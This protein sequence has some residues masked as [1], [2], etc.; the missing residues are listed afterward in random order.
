MIV[1][2]RGNVGRESTW[3]GAGILSPLLPWDYADSVNRLSEYSRGLFQAWCA[4]LQSLSGI[5]PEF[6]NTGMLVL[7]PF[8]HPRAEAWCLDH[9]WRFARRNSGD[10]L[11]GGATEDALW[12]P[13][14][15]QVRNPRLVKTLR[16]AAKAMGVD[17]RENVQVT[18]FE[19]QDGHIRRVLTKRE[20][21]SVNTCIIAAGAWSGDFPGLE[22][23]SQRIYPVRGQIL[24][25]KQTLGCL[26]SVIYCNGHYMVPRADGH[27]LVGSTL[28]YVGFDKSTTETARREIQ[29]FAV[30]LLPLLAD[31]ELI[32]HWSGLRP[33][34]P[35]N[36]PVIG[37]H[38]AYENLF[39]NSGHFRYGVTMAPGSA[40][41]LTSLIFSE[42]PP[43][44]PDDYMAA[45]QP[46]EK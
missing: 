7:P 34:S 23:F 32:S 20:A 46:C 26:S 35:D 36:L 2:E 33:G 12:L 11:S 10:F 27:I 1:L 45:C 42:S 31:A 3:A 9:G 40:K 5:D 24:L 29:D 44:H 18:G 4:S 16:G 25:F 39:I 30:T 21:Y 19:S 28:E 15:A 13:D 37:R 43:I 22:G 17:V 14:V 41:L 38:P 6:R 8:D